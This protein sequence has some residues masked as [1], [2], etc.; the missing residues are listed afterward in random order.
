MRLFAF[1]HADVHTPDCRGL[2]LDTL[3][4]V[5]G[6]S[7]IHVAHL[8]AGG[9]LGRQAAHHRQLLAVVSGKAR[10]ASGDGPLHTV[11]T[12]TLVLWEEG[13]VHQAW[14]VTDLVAVMI[15]GVGVFDF[16][17]TFREL[18]PDP[19]PQPQP[20]PAPV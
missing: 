1:P 14:A 19:A 20:Q 12:G 3:P 16:G 4:G 10:V 5:M 13:E 8:S 18:T 7:S 6:T 2:T 15:E 11:E 9:R 17:A